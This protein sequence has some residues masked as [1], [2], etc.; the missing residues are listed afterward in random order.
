MVF[1]KKLLPI[2]VPCVVLCATPSQAQAEESAMGDSMA[3][4]AS[5]PHRILEVIARAKHLI[6]SPYRAGGTTPS[7]FDCSGFMQYVFR[8]VDVN[9]PRT[10][11]DM[12]GVG[13]RVERSELQQGDM[14]FF[15]HSGGR[16]SHVGMYVG[17]G[18]FIHSPSSG[19][20]VEITRLDSR[21]WSPRF[22]TARRV[23]G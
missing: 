18:Q 2:A 5:D 23:L 6:G 13:V 21:Y 8:M 10:S 22:V 14:V 4:N 20:T 19:K 1:V 16:I 9:L 15:A 3:V 17:D 11:R 12:A 7:G